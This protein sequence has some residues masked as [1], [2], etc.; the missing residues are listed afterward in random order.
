MYANRLGN[1]LFECVMSN[2]MNNISLNISQ[3]PAT[4]LVMR[5]SSLKSLDVS[6]N[7]RQLQTPSVLICRTTL[8]RLA[9]KFTFTECKT[10]A[11]FN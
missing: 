3:F 5:T 4:N 11:N 2:S 8:K 7:V 10:R 1:Q 9:T 6:I